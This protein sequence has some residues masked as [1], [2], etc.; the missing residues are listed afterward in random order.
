MVPQ[1]LQTVKG[2]DGVKAGIALIPLTVLQSAGSALC[3]FLVTKL[4]RYKIIVLAGFAV[5]SLGIGLLISIKQSTS[6]EIIIVYCV[7]A[8]LGSG[9]CTQT[10]LLA[11]QCAVSRKDMAVVTSARNFFRLLGGTLGLAFSYL[12]LNIDVTSVKSDSLT[13]E[14]ILSDPIVLFE[15]LDL[16]PALRER[17][18]QAYL[19]G[20]RHV[21]AFVTAFLLLALVLSTFGMKELPL[22]RK[23]DEELEKKGEDF[24]KERK[25]EGIDVEANEKTNSA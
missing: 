8:G 7:V 19:D 24:M 1:L 21:F 23:D 4:Q 6:L 9:A 16:E 12:I 10:Q 11:A 15:E 3:G 20:F 25:G 2:F 5:Y 13:E 18:L 17:Y 14:T 22:S